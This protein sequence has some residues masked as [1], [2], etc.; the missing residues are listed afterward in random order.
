MPGGGQIL[1]QHD[2]LTIGEKLFQDLRSNSTET[3]AG[4]MVGYLGFEQRELQDT[5]VLK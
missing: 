5:F 1:G 4:M 2:R 3:S